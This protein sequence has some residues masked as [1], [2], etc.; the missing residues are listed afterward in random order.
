[1]LKVISIVETGKTVDNL[2]LLEA[3]KFE[4]CTNENLSLGGLIVQEL[5]F[6]NGKITKVELTNKDL[7]FN[8]SNLTVVL[9][10][11]K[12][13]WYPTLIKI[14]DVSLFT[15]LSFR[16]D[17]QHFLTFLGY[18]VEDHEFYN[19]I[20]IDNTVYKL[21]DTVITDN[22]PVF[23][24]SIDKGLSLNIDDLI[25]HRLKVH[26]MVKE[27][28]DISNNEGFDIAS[29]VKEIIYG[30][31]SDEEINFNVEYDTQISGD[32]CYINIPKEEHENLPEE[33]KDEV[34]KV[35]KSYQRRSDFLKRITLRIED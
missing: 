21:F 33:V 35:I 29:K 7:D 10:L 22:Q 8:K 34:N 25:H 17:L 24:F 32:V 3:D 4:M 9:E 28:N 26:Q 23:E 27:D 14:P 16:S 19:H 18:E 2:S 13:Q 20:T 5:T 31:Y 12:R 11:K 1:M 6:V 15:F 30:T